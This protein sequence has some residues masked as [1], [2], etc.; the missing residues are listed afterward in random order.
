VARLLAQPLGLQ[1][2]QPVVID[3]RGGAATTIGAMA[4]AN[5]PKDGHTLLL[6][7][8]TTFTTVPH[9]MKVRYGL[10]DFEPVSMVVKVPFAFVVKKDFPAKTIDEFRAYA[11]AQ[12]GAVNNATNGAGSLVHLAGEL[13][14]KELGIKV[15]Q[16]H[17][18]GA[19]PATTD[20]LAGVVDSNVEA[21]TSALPNV[22]TGAYRALAVLSPQR[23]PQLPDVPT[24]VE[25]GYPNVQV[26]TF[27][28]VLAPAGTP[29][30]VIDRL[31][32]EINRVVKA[33]DFASRMQEIGNLAVGMT[34]EELKTYITQESA[35]W[36][37]VVKES[38][39]EVEQ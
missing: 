16:V 12:P 2:G 5:A 27:F 39:I 23:L 36:G 35:K 13:V 26:E 4:V 37:R 1:L 8:A 38:G 25:L 33:A 29:H 21:L 28:A 22:R 34:P 24:F 31:S 15:T 20:M 18:R 11:L 3:N 10:S 9:I 19:A 17:Y 32:H 14:A 30:A 6:A 7:S